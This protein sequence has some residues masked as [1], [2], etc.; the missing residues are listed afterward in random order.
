MSSPHEYRWSSHR[1]YLGKS[2]QPWVHTEFGLRMFAA[3]E[4]QA[5]MLYRAFVERS[6]T[7][8]DPMQEVHP[9]ERRVLGDDRLLERLSVPVLRRAAATTLERITVDVCRSFG[10]DLETVRSASRNRRLSQ[11]RAQIARHAIHLQVS[12][13]SEVARFLNRSSSSVSRAIERYRSP[14]T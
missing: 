10:V 2:T 4:A 11:A 1:V 7:T 3:D 5:R 9:S 12:T 13:L 14:S 6:G 8:I